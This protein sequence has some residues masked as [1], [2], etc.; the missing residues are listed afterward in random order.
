MEEKV[1]ERDQSV[2][3][4]KPGRAAFGERRVDLVPGQKEGSA[5]GQ[6]QPASTAPFESRRAEMT[7]LIRSTRTLRVA[8][9]SSAKGLPQI[10]CP[11]FP[12]PV[13]SPV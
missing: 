5:D 2:W 10:D 13:G 9:I 8:R 7:V 1:I 4:V 11:P 12:E 6:H 3:P